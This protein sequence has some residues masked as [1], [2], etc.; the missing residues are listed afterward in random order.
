MK[1]PWIF[2]LVVGLTA[3]ATEPLGVSAFQGTSSNMLDLTRQSSFIFAGSV[4]KVNAASPSTIPASEGTAIVRVDDV[5]RNA[6]VVSDVQGKDITVELSRPGSLKER[7]QAIFFTNVVMYGASLV[8][9]EVNHISSESATT[10][11]QVGEALRQL[12]DEEL[13]A[14]LDQADLVVTGR[15][16]VV[17]AVNARAERAPDS[18]HDPDWWQASVQVQSVEK[19]QPAPGPVIVYFPHSVDIRWFASPK[20]KVGQQGLFIL[21]QTRDEKLKV[22]GFTALHPL[23]FQTTVQRQ[24]IRSLIQK[25]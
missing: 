4:Q 8:V 15:V 16:S 24:R 12:P 21:R 23:D 25:R 2:L 11:V 3:L 13:K 17:R 22:S 7:E 5:L 14:R 18:E 1:K 9:R 19:G 6:G 20:F 10:K